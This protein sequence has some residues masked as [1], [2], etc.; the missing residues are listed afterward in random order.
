MSLVNKACI[1]WIKWSEVEEDEAHRTFRDP[2][3]FHAQV[4]PILLHLAP[5]GPQRLRHR[6]P[7]IG[8]MPGYLVGTATLRRVR[9]AAPAEPAKA[10]SPCNTALRPPGGQWQRPAATWQRRLAATA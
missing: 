6:R 8:W 3:S 4:L 7:P 5:K 2:Q 9:M 10:I 1:K